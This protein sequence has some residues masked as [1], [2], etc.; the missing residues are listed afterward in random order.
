MREF[1]PQRRFRIGGVPIAKHHPCRRT[2]VAGRYCD[3]GFG[4]RKL[5]H[6]TFSIAKENDLKAMI[7]MWQRELLLSPDGSFQRLGTGPS[8]K[9]EL[10]PHRV[11]LLA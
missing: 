7:G 9:E 5:L 1:M 6:I 3:I 2:V 10:L 4:P 8:S 11:C